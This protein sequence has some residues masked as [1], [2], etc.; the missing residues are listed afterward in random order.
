MISFGKSEEYR[1]LPLGMYG[2]YVKDTWIPEA[3]AHPQLACNPK[4]TVYQ[5]AAHIQ[6]AALGDDGSFL[7]QHISMGVTRSLLSLF[8][9]AGSA[10]LVSPAPALSLPFHRHDP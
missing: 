10:L 6:Q 9:S 3:T 2:K 8:M 7:G 1:L 5:S 4:P